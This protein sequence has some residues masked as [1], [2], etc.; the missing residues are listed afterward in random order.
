[1]GLVVHAPAVDKP[2]TSSPRNSFRRRWT[3]WWNRA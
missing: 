1:M 3:S 2:R